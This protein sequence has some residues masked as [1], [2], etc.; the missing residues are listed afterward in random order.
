M[1]NYF[2]ISKKH[3]LFKYYWLTTFLKWFSFISL[4]FFFLFWINQI[5]FLGKSF[6]S[7][8]FS[9][10]NILLL[11]LYSLSFII[12]FIFPI[13][14]FL[15]LFWLLSYLISQKEILAWQNS[16]VSLKEIVKV[17]FRFVFTLSFSFFIFSDFLQS[18]SIEGQK[19]IFQNWENS[20]LIKMKKDSSHLRV[21]DLDLFNISYNN[22]FNFYILYPLK[23]YQRAF[24]LLEGKENESGEGISLKEASFFSPSLTN[25]DNYYQ[26]DIDYFSFKIESFFKSLDNNFSS[27]FLPFPVLSYYYFLKNNSLKKEHVFLWHQKLIN[28]I[29]SWLLAFLAILFSFKKSKDS[30]NSYPFWV[31][32]VLA[33]AYI[34]LVLLMR[35]LFFYFWEKGFFIILWVPVIILLILVPFSWFKEVF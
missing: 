4:L 9:I 18:Y 1:R 33:L 31:G 19:K 15:S 26:G 24:F 32:L 23:E 35:I 27:Y 6:L 22:S 8:N 2:L 21:G 30:Q 5:L 16:G 20:L 11:S 34:F 17:L 13:I 12:D 14:I 10:Y 29:S 7:L 3:F 25:S 28:L